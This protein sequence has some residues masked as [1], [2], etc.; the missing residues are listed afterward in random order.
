MQILLIAA[1]IAATGA[2]GYFIFNKVRE[3]RRIYHFHQEQE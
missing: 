3:S 2:L 1:A